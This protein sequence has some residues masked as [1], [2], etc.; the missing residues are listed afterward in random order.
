MMFK[1]FIV[2]LQFLT[3][4]CVKRDLHTTEEEFGKSAAFFPVVGLI[5]GGMQILLFFALERALPPSILAVFLLLAPVVLTGAFHL[6]GLSDT[7][8]G[9]LSGRDREGM[10]RIMKDSHVGT[11]GMIAV[12]SLMLAKLV[13]LYEIV[14][15]L[16]PSLIVG[17]LLFVPMLSRWAMVISAGVSQYAR[18]EPGLGGA[19]T[20]R[21]G[22]KLI[23]L[24]G[25]VPV[26]AAAVYLRIM[27]GFYVIITILTALLASWVS[28]RKIGG[29]TGDVLGGI[30]EITEVILLF[31]VI[32]LNS[33]I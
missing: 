5:V 33:A 24:S 8:D 28:K 9:F 3:R 16:N 17:V 10:L 6:E 25:L 1:G 14:Q 26:I 32:L 12:V 31:S 11:M 19:F 18:S 30:N 15:S 22:I 27:G 23:I 7:A 2:A 29:A 13:F 4:I 21:V 20:E